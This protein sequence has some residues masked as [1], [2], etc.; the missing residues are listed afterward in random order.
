M[1]RLNR[2]TA[3]NV[4]ANQT[5][6]GLPAAFDFTKNRPNAA[7]A[8][9]DPSSE[10]LA[11]GIGSSY[12]IIGYK[13]KVWSLRYR[14]EKHMFVRADDGTPISY[15]DVVVLRQAKSKS[16]SFYDGG[17]DETQSEGKPP[18]CASIDGV[19]PDVG[20]TA[21]QS[22]SCALCSHNV[23]KTDANGRK[24]RDCTDY[25]RL[26]VLL[27]P[28]QTAAL[29]GSPLMEPVFLRVPPASLND[30]AVMGEQ[31]ANQGWHFS[32]FILRISFDPAV[33]HPKFVF[34]PIQPLTEKE[35]AVV[36]PLRN[37]PVALRI[38]GEDQSEVAAGLAPPP[39]QAALTAPAASQ[40][41]GQAVPAPKP[42]AGATAPQGQAAPPRP[43][44]A[45]KPAAAP[46]P[47]PVA[48]PPKPPA[49]K[50]AAPK[51][52]APKPTPPPPPPLPAANAEE[53]VGDTGFGV[54]EVEGAAPIEMEIIPPEGSAQAA[55]QEA[56]V[57]EAAPA[58]APAEDT[59]AG[60]A[61]AGL[62]DEIAAL[63]KQ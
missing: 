56:A 13:G 12:G 6:G 5:Q 40:G 46:A 55:P 4:P 38:T 14:G 20:V 23:W 54:A 30:L 37:D 63:L 43:A 52:A 2:S 3:M 27:L 9:L 36:L 22:E 51:S 7:F 49:P 17:F 28:K 32:T 41:T 61:D 29:L 34:R 8:T 10:S 15:I 25:K 26:A 48:A 53:P 31:M 24:G 50:P 58:E 16:K 18:T 39:K 47:K 33:S 35:A 21:P 45:P 60:T 19:R 1:M 44:P 59:D 57:A 11:D 62:D 42:P